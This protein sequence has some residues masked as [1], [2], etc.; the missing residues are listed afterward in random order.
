MG[1]SNDLTEACN[2]TVRAAMG[3]VFLSES[4]NITSFTADTT[5]QSFSAV[6]MD[7]T[8]NLWYEY[9]FE[10]ESKS[11]NGEGNSDGGT[12]TFTNTFEGK[13]IGLD[14]TKLKRLQD[15]IESRKLTAI[16]ET[17]NKVGTYNRAFVVGWDDVIG[18]D[19]WAKP[20]VNTIIEAALDGENSATLQLVAK[21][22]ELIREYVGTIETN[23]S[24]T[25]TLGS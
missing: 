15:L 19:A 25:V 8:A 14:K 3:R 13:V 1:L 10:F 6:V 20:N 24:G 18:K 4:C 7:S 16:V 23:A 12:S 5:V 22:A 17:T 9:E 21:H 2:E 11:F